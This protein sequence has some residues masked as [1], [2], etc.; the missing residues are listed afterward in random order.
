MLL[1]IQ[2]IIA[3][4]IFTILIMPSFYKNPLA[5]I[6]SYPPVIRKRIESLPQYKDIIETKKK[7][8]I[9]A[10]YIF[11]CVLVI[12]LGLIAYFSNAR[13]FSSAFFHVF[14]LFFVVNIYDVIILDIGIFCRS[15]RAIIPGTEDMIDEYRSPWHHV[16]GGFIGVLLGAVVSLC[17]AGFVYLID[18]L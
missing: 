9:L 6:M 14:I 15:K 3:C 8:H 10:K 11:A 16:K 13:T 4:F 17:S 12:I 18:L 5:H 1:I 7:K 2:S